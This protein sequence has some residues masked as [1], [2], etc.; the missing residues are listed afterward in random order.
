MAINPLVEQLL[1]VHKRQQ[2]CQQ[3]LDTA[4][5]NLFKC[6]QIENPNEWQTLFTIVTTTAM[7]LDIHVNT[8]GGHLPY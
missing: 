8:L 6:S 2:E 1:T 5:E 3:Q 7:T 4:R